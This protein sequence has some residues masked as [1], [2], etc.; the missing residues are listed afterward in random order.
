MDPAPAHKIL[1]L[2]KLA[3][4]SEVNGS[5]GVCKFGVLLNSIFGSRRWDIPTVGSKV[6]LLTTNYPKHAKPHVSR[7]LHS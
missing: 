5:G 2:N 6:H 1:K 3:L 7:E 4:G